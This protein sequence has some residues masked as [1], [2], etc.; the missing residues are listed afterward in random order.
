MVPHLRS[1]IQTFFDEKLAATFPDASFVFD[2]YIP[3]PHRRV[4]LIDVN[5]WAPRTDPLLFSWLEILNTRGFLG[6]GGVRGDMSGLMTV[7]GLD[8]HSPHSRSGS[9]SNDD[10]DDDDENSDTDSKEEEE[11]E[12]PFLPEVRLVKKDDPEAY[13]FTSPQYSAHKLPKDV[14]D[15]SLGG[16]EG[17]GGLR[18]F[19][20]RWRD[21]VRRQEAE[22]DE[23][24]E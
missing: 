15:A 23:G 2:V 4:W 12:L 8:R 3:P 6:T 16:V 19:M 24:S 11:E 18:E 10:D 5:P 21:I 20:G 1:L 17:E 14:V 13:S 9:A 7:Q 22:D